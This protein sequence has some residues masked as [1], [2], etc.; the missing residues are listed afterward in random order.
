M[1]DQ[2]GAP[3]FD[4]DGI[5]T[6]GVIVRHLV[7]PSHRQD[8]IALL[9]R[10]AD[11]VP[12]SDIKLSLMSQYTPYF[13]ADCEFQNL[14]RRLTTFEYR[15]VLDRATEL[16]FDGYFQELSSADSTYTPDFEHD[17]GLLDEKYKN[18]TNG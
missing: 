12:V 16:G 6:G 4:A 1:L 5:M 7:L 18:D 10:L 3:K 17:R 9:E 15:S 8:S 14:H 13:A 2:V 11:T